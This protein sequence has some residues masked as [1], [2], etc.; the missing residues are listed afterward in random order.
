MKIFVQQMFR[1]KPT[2]EHSFGNQF[3]GARRCNNSGNSFAVARL[4]ITFSFVDAPRKPHFPMDFLGVFRP[5]KSE[6]GFS[7]IQA[8][9]LVF[10]QV[11]V[12]LFGRKPRA[13][14]S[15]ISFCSRLFAAVAPLGLGAI[16]LACSAAWD[17]V[18]CRFLF[19]SAF[20]S[21]KTDSRSIE[22]ICMRRR[23]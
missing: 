5:G 21:R 3:C 12:D 17:F 4:A 9:F 8:T 10:R 7:A 15:P 11:M 20:S 23:Y 13:S 2:R 18:R 14:F 22:R 16:C 6:K 19:S 1:P